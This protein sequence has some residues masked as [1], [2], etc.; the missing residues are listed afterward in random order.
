MIV[1]TA[2]NEAVYVAVVDGAVTVRDVLVL[3]LSHS[4][5]A[6][7]TPWAD[8]GDVTLSVQELPGVHVS[9]IGLT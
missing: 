3:L 9:V 5:N 8:C 4:P 7:S 2:L 6:Y 1:A